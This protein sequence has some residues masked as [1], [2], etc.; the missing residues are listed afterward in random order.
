[1]Q[2]NIDY[3]T[4]NTGRDNAFLYQQTPSF[5]GLLLEWE[6]LSRY[7]RHF[8]TIYGLMGNIRQQQFFPSQ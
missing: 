5:S 2:M 6:V 4:C 1:M 8:I 3:I 7:M